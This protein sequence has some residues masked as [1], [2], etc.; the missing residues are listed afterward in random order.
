MRGLERGW[1]AR[2]GR[3]SGLL[4]FLCIAIPAV[5]ALE[6]QSGQVA[7]GA[8]KP[9]REQAVRPDDDPGRSFAFDL[10]SLPGGGVAFSPST[11]IRVHR[12]DTVS[13]RN[14]AGKTISLSF[15]HDDT[16]KKWRV[17]KQLKP[18]KSYSLESGEFV[19]FEVCVGDIPKGNVTITAEEEAPLG[20]VRHP[21]N[22]PGMQIYP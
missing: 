13:F 7:A 5:L 10:S 21:V 16:S 15:T 14:F 2:C 1:V 12:G 18:G 11:G 6:Q 20:S 4:L 8:D 22:G 19:Q 9:P 17:F 3:W